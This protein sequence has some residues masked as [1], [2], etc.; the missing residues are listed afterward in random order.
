[1]CIEPEV[2]GV[3]R[4]HG[5]GQRAFLINNF[6]DSYLAKHAADKTKTDSL[7]ALR[8]QVGLV[9]TADYEPCA[10]EYMTTWLN[11]EVV[12]QALHVTAD[13]K[14]VAWADCSRSIRYKQS[15]GMK[16]MTPY[17]N[18]L[19]DGKF[20]LNLVVYSGDDDDVCA[21][22]GTQGWIWDLGYKVAGKSWQQ[23]LVNGQTAGYLTKWENT[24][25]A[26]A[27][28]RGAGHEVPTYKPEAA[29]QLF[30][31]YLNGELTNA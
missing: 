12:K 23:W 24:G 2:N 5:R 1:M 17:Y 4:S 28:V 31:S 6:F 20:G 21:T 14:G 26:F 29:L 7:L 19:I 3:K 10:D 30:Q 11:T 15:D 13:N 9:E 27:T 22:V 8:K 16:D 25:F 18:Y